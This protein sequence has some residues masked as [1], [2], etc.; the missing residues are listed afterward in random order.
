MILGIVRLIVFLLDT[1]LWIPVA[2]VASLAD[3][4]A[5]L[6]YR[7]ARRWAWFNV[8]LLGTRVLVRGLEHLDPTKSYVF[9][10]NHRSNLDVLALVVA[11]WDFQLRWVA[12]L[13]LIH[14]PLFGWALKATKQIIVNR[15][16]HA[17]AIAS[18]MLAKERIG[19][20]LSIVFFPEGTRSRGEMLPFKKGGFVLAIKTGT[21]IVPI[22]I[23]G[24][25]KILP[26]NGWIVRRGG[27]VQIVICPPIPTAT[28][29]LADRDALL[30][31]VE[32]AITA[33]TEGAA[34][35]GAVGAN[36]AAPRTAVAWL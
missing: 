25:A 18:L 19:H 27:D 6:A 23:S 4:D 22:G 28:L 32:G 26:R 14:I 3:P 7:F 20:G 5:K 8:K 9:I 35:P 15:T 13:E 30:A 36:A 12:K 16:D 24:T 17:Q 33:C 10:S 11:L 29:S 34:G 31:Q 1:A 2:L 21:P